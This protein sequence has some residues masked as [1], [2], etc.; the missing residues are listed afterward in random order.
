[1]LHQVFYWA[2]QLPP[3]KKVGFLSLMPMLPMWF[4]ASLLMLP[5][6]LVTLGTRSWGTR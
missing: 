6:A 5:W 4:A 2:F 1:M 3:A